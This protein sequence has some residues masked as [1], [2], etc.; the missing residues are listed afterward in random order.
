MLTHSHTN[1][2]KPGGL[3]VL[4]IIV[5]LSIGFLCLLGRVTRKFQ[6]NVTS[7]GS[8]NGRKGCSLCK[9]S[10]LQIQPIKG[11]GGMAQLIN[12]NPCRIQARR[13]SEWTSDPS[14]PATTWERKIGNPLGSS[15]WPGVS[16]AAETNEI[17]CLNKAG[18]DP[19]LRAASDLHTCT[20]AYTQKLIIIIIKSVQAKEMTQPEK[21]TSCIQDENQNV[22]HR[23]KQG[24]AQM[25]A[26]PFEHVNGHMRTH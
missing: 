5:Q 11:G 26:H 12:Q 14:T 22:T 23:S 15:C 21:W 2:G 24:S 16:K 9:G 10:N 3:E 25:H 18:E 20:V 7:P 1:T 13:G 6:A 4:A 19:V 8:R 17:T